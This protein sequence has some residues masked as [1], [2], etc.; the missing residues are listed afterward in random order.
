MLQEQNTELAG[1]WNEQSF[2]GKELF[3][4]NAS[5]E[6]VLL[7]NNNIK[8]RVIASVTDDNKDTVVKDLT[9]KFEAVVSK[10]REL[11][12]E[13][14]ATDDK[15]KL[16][17]K[18]AQLKEYL[19]TVD[20]LGDFSQP[21]LLVLGWEHIIHN[22]TQEIYA[23][24]LKLAELAESLADS[25]QWKDTAMAFRDIAD[26]W[27][28]TGHID[29]NRNDKLW[30]RIEAARKKFLDR[31][32]V[33]Y[34][35][36]EK[37]ML[38][39]MDLKIEL[40][41]QAES[42][43]AS[44]EWKKTADAFT[45]LTEEWK[46]IGPTHHKKNEELWQRFI[47]AKGAF[48]D[49]KR[50]HGSRIQQEHEANYAVKLALVEKAEELKESRNWNATAQAYATLMEDWKKTGRTFQEKGDELWNR[51]I[52]A[53][54]HFFEAKKTHFKEI[55][56]NLEDNYQRK[57]ELYE[58]AEQIKNSTRWR[59]TADEMV[60]LMEEWKK[61][62]PVPRSYGDQMWEDFN[63]ARKHFFARKDANRQER[64]QQ[65]E[66]E[67][68]YRAAK[69]KGRVGELELEIK[70]EEEKIA[71]FKNG[72]ENITPGKKAKELSAHLQQLIIEGGEKIKQLQRQLEQAKNDL[73]GQKEEP[74]NHDTSGD[75]V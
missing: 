33:H 47:T 45:R 43:A 75:V 16:A 48:F 30:N 50:E 60:E 39:N 3:Y 12:T 72:L 2:P 41:E 13:W 58:R 21:F 8:E 31:K 54:N 52:E 28:Q 67:K 56:D 55:K 66:E 51:F 71:D 74:V 24:K 6:I 73:K 7:A 49:R 18:I 65:F 64:K 4:L 14:Q 59:E 20:A 32:Q 69:A 37:D 68:V 5:G 19:Y 62:G 26:K 40:V 15:T 44:E 27:K 11:E 57:K 36:E 38:A 46:K 1:W 70:E 35:E 61:I 17:E 22:L 10:V 42:M 34:E 25:D 63:A 53:K 9:G 23:A 29:R